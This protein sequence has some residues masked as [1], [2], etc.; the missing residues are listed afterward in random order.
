MGTTLVELVVVIAILG[1]IAGITGWAVGKVPDMPVVD[2]AE[3]RIAAARREAIRSGRSVTLT[4]LWEGRRLTATAHS[5]G[6]IVGDTTLGI[7][8]FSERIGR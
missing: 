2:S 1:V 7:P 5:D 4:V 6:S 8:R 3:A